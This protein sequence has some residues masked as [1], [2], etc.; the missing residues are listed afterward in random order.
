MNA[1]LPVMNWT[2]DDVDVGQ[3]VDYYADALSSSIVPMQLEACSSAGFYAHMEAVE[4]GGFAVIH[5]RGSAHR[6]YTDARDL[7]RSTG[8]HY[9]LILNRSTE[10]RIAHRGHKRMGRGEAVFVDSQFEADIDSPSDYDY[11]HI[12]F[13]AGWAR[14][15]LPMPSVLT[16]AHIRT[17]S[18][19][20]QAL[21]AFAAG[22]T[23][24][25]LNQATQPLPLLVDHL[26]SLLALTAQECAAPPPEPREK[27]LAPV[28]KIRDAMQQLCC[29]PALTAS[30]VAA[31][32]GMPLRSFHRSFTRAQTTFGAMLTQMRF[33]RAM[34]MLRSPLCRRLTIAEIAA[35]AGF[36]DASHLSAVVRARSGQTPTQVRRGA[37]DQTAESR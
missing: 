26:G 1:V 34:D 31:A 25:F 28:D 14:Q 16:G 3:G 35:R 30:E 17:D 6:C 33:A 4:L 5:Q 11:I 7:A 29:S 27:V 23:P 9:H 12:K 18:G 24:R 13:T 32:V 15:W 21:N 22:L 36:C 19:W 8:Q 37:L 20:G 10:W 2:T